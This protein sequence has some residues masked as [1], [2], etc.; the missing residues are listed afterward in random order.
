MPLRRKVQVFVYRTAPDFEVLLL[1]RAE[2][3]KGQWQPVTGN[4]DPHEQ[5][6][7]SA[8]RET[9]EET[10]FAIEPQP[11]GITFTFEKEGQ[12]YHETVF[13]ASAPEDEEVEISDE[14][15]QF[16]WLSASEAESRLQFD[17]QKRALKALADRHAPKA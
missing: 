1:R 3:N 4:V 6:R 14:H 16:E 13:A 15:D 17:D 10:G 12:R 8:I 2:K 7:A 5:V 9:V 11:L